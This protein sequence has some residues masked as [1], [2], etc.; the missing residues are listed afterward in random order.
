MYAIQSIKT[1]KFLYA[2]TY[3][4]VILTSVPATRKRSLTAL[5]QKPH[6]T[7]GLREKCLL[8]RRFARRTF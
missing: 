5:S 4:T 7:F 6:K 3:D 2:Q 8:S 1:G